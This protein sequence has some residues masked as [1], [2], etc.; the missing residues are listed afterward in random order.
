MNC[1]CVAIVTQLAALTG[2]R[3]IDVLARRREQCETMMDDGQTRFENLSMADQIAFMVI[4]R[5]SRSSRMSPGDILLRL[6][7]ETATARADSSDLRDAVVASLRE[8]R[9]AVGDEREL[10]SHV[11]HLPRA[12]RD[13]RPT[14]AVEVR[15][16]E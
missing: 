6:L 12:L 10:Q 11:G 13:H 15:G 5:I 7:V 14:R 9:D 3:V 2:Q 4:I 8:R 1:Q 16:V